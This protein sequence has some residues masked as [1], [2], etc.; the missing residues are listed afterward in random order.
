M[1]Y[2][3]KCCVA[4]SRQVL[5]SAVIGGMLA[6]S[7]IAIFLVPVTFYVVEKFAAKKKTKEAAV[8]TEPPAPA[9]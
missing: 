2:K 8:A 5:G 9:E 3:G 6:S 4:V 7:A 1:L